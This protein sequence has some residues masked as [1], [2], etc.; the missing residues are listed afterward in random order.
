MYSKRL[1]YLYSMRFIWLFLFLILSESILYAEVLITKEKALQMAFSDADSLESRTLILTDDK[2]ESIKKKYRVN[3]SSRIFSFNIA[4]KNGS[5]IGYSVTDT[6]TLRTKSQTIMIFLNPDG[7]LK[8]VEILA[9]YEP[10]E[11]KVSGRW[12][13]LF[14]NKTINDD[15]RS[16]HNIPN[17]TGATISSHGTSEAVRRALAIFDYYMKEE[18]IN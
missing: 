12:L 11:Y 17:I 4:R 18:G 2:A 1:N 13:D 5:I 7:N 10:P 8:Y 14:K 16:G 15:L 6:H 9:F 3:I